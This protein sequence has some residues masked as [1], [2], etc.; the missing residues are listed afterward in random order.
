[1][2]KSFT[3]CLKR[4]QSAGKPLSCECKQILAFITTHRETHRSVLCQVLQPCCQASR[5]ATKSTYTLMLDGLT[6]RTNYH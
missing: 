5:S 1:M 6:D 3:L 2:S 4:Q